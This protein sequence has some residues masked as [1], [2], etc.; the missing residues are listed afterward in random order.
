MNQKTISNLGTPAGRRLYQDLW[1]DLIIEQ[2]SAVVPSLLR[3]LRTAISGAEVRLVSKDAS[4]SIGH[5]LGLRHGFRLFMEEIIVRHYFNNVQALVYF[6]AVLLLLFLGLRFAGLLSEEVALIGIGIEACMLLI[7]FLVLFYSPEDDHHEIVELEVPEDPTASDEE[8]ARDVIREVLDE[9][10]DIGGTYAT[11][12]M[13]MEQLARAQEESIRELAQRVGAIQGLNLL[14]SHA[15]RLETTNTLLSQLTTAIA[16]MNQRID[17]M[18][19]KELEYHVRREME[20]ILRHGANGTDLTIP[21]EQQPQ[22]A[23]Q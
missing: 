15:E 4:Y 20:R 1:H 22:G 6:G 14:E 11:L 7:L 19:G 17:M 18:F 23:Q 9:I 12:G 2:R 10:E 8:D 21:T 5:P 13:K 16:G 3:L